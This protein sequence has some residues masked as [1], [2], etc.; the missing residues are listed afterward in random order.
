M[1]HFT[2]FCLFCFL[3]KIASP[4]G[5]AITS[6]PYKHPIYKSPNKS[7]SY[8]PTSIIPLKL[9]LTASA[10]SLYVIPYQ[11]SFVRRTLTVIFFSSRSSPI[12]VGIRN[13]ALSGSLGTSVSKNYA[14]PA[15]NISRNSGV[16][17]HMF[18]DTRDS[19]SMAMPSV[20]APSTVLTIFLVSTTSVKLF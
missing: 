19:V 2:F 4:P 10:S 6:H 18:M 9:S 15:S 14:N 1:F 11:V 17:P 7:F 16:S 20:S 8:I 3:R 12:N 13:S 5:L